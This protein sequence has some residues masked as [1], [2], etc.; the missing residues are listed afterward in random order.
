MAEITR[1]RKLLNAY[2][3]LLELKFSQTYKND[4]GTVFKGQ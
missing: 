3:L 1:M 2:K 4:H